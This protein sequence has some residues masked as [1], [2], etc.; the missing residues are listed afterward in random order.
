MQ[1][2]GSSAKAGLPFLSEAMG[3]CDSVV[4]S[5]HPA[6]RIPSSTSN[7]LELLQREELDADGV[8]KAI[9]FDP[10]LTGLVL[11]VANSVLIAGRVE[12]ASIRAALLHLGHKRLIATVLGSAIAPRMAGPVVT[13]CDAMPGNLWE[14]GVGVALAAEELVRQSGWI[15]PADAFA[16]GLFAGVGKLGLASTLQGPSDSS[17]GGMPDGAMPMDKTEREHLKDDHGEAGAILLKG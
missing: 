7:L 2:I 8:C 10:V 13:C 1:L 14:Q 4:G 11:A 6:P 5:I 15:N 12:V 16:A 3:Y 9:A 17:V